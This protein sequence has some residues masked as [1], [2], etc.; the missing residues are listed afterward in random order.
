MVANPNIWPYDFKPIQAPVKHLRHHS[1][2]LID[3]SES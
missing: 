1:Y 2:T 3:T